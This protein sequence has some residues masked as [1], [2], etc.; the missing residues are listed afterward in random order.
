MSKLKLG[1]LGTY[2]EAQNKPDRNNL[3]KLAK[4]TLDTYPLGE[5]IKISAIETKQIQSLQNYSQER[6]EARLL[7]ETYNVNM[8]AII[9]NGIWV[10]YDRESGLIYSDI[11]PIN[12]AHEIG[13]KLGLKHPQDN[14]T[15]RLCKETYRQ[16]KCKHSREIMGCAGLLKK[17]I[18]FSDSDTIALKNI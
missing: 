2:K 14:C 8:V 16:N 6:K 7:E 18:G 15:R 3:Y 4:K 13:H 11:N 5:I 10:H 17:T 1:I 9:E 12:L